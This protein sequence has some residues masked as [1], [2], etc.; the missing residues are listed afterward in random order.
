[1]SHKSH[2]SGP[3]LVWLSF[4]SLQDL[5]NF[6]LLSCMTPKAG[7]SLSDIKAVVYPSQV[8]DF[9]LLKKPAVD[10]GQIDELKKSGLKALANIVDDFETVPG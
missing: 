8:Q 5:R 10:S 2:T 6:Q 3:Y 7:Q 9:E 4:S 1:M